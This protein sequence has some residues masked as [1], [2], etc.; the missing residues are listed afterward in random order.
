MRRPT[1]EDIR[2]RAYFHWLNKTHHNW[3]DPVA[4]WLRAEIEAYDLRYKYP[5]IV[6]DQNCFR[7]EALTLKIKEESKIFGWQILL[8]DVSM[9]EMLK[10]QQWETSMRRSLAYLASSPE[11]VSLALSLGDLMRAE[12]ASGEPI[13]DLVDGLTTPIFR[14]LLREIDSGIDGA[15]F[16]KVR[17]GI[18]DAQSL[19]SQQSLRHTD[20]KAMLVSLIDAWRKELSGDEVRKLKAT[21]QN[22]VN[23]WASV[24]MANTCVIGLKNGG[25]P[26]KAAQVL[27]VE[28]SVSGCWVSCL[29]ALALNWLVFGGIDSLPPEKATN[30]LVDLDYILLGVLS[31]ELYSKENRVRDLYQNM[32]YVMDARWKWVRMSNTSVTII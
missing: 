15:I 31:C 16:A 2:R 8:P 6:I 7:D 25:Y 21:P 11:L 1:E 26:D 9:M 3:E 17:A 4:N 27:S 29:S 20:N 28:P 14:Q 32:G 22:Q 13:G 12:R 5:Y 19:A 10:G 23:L 30:D 18:V 24:Q